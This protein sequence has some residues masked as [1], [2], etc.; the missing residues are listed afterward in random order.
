MALA[1]ATL[2]LSYSIDF[3]RLWPAYLVVLGLTG[4]AL[5]LL[6]VE[7]IYPLLHRPY[8]QWDALANIA[9]FGLV[10]FSW[11]HEAAMTVMVPNSWS[12]SIEMFWYILLALYFG[13]TQLRLWALALIGAIMLTLSTGECLT[14]TSFGYGPYCFQSRYGVLEAG[15]IPFAMGGLLQF[16]I[17]KLA[18][19]F[20]RWRWQL[21]SG[22]I[23]ATCVIAVVPA[24]RYTVGPF[25]GIA[26]VG[27]VV[28][29]SVDRDR[30]TRVTDFFGRASYHLF[31]AQWVLAAMLVRTTSLTI[32]SLTLCVATLI[33]SLGLS[34]LL[35]PLEHR[36]ER[37]RRNLRP[38]TA[39]MKAKQR[40]LSLNLFSRLADEG[41]GKRRTLRSARTVP[42][43][44]KPSE[45]QI[46]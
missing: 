29:Y 5:R 14:N 36:I 27:C 35:V 41:Q 37:I 45:P 18:A 25:L 1:R 44:V 15:F 20:H 11:T 17:T 23:A 39:S 22:S 10:G 9:V 19:A 26:I 40:Q 4:V 21:V 2:L 46:I 7:G 34:G 13:K 38:S 33:L 30:S 24:F 42:S 16:H 12:L 8:D 6:N 3:L 31:I 32:N 43:A 28:A